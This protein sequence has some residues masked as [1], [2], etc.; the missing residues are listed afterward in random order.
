ML[1]LAL[2]LAP[3]LL[4]LPQGPMSG[5]V[6][7]NE[8]VVDDEGS[9]DREF[10]ELYNRSEQRVDLG[11]CVLEVLNRRGVR[12]SYAIPA[13]S[14]IEPCAHFVLG[15]PSVP[16]VD[17]SLG[18]GDLFVDVQAGALVLRDAQGVELDRLVYHATFGLWT[19]AGGAG[20]GF[21]GESTSFDGFETSISRWR[22]GWDDLPARAWVLQR[23]TPGEANAQEWRADG[24]DEFSGAVGSAHEGWQGTRSPLV[25]IDPLQVGPLDPQGRPWNPIALPRDSASAGGSGGNCGSVWN[26]AG[27]GSAALWR[28]EPVEELEVEGLFWLRSDA[29][30][31]AQMETWSFGIQGSTDAYAR[32]ADP[33]GAIGFVR[34]GNT[35]VAWI[36]QALD[37]GVTLYLVDHGDGGWAPIARSAPALR[38]SIL[39]RAGVNDGWQRLRLRASQGQLEAEFGGVLGVPGS[40]QVV[41]ATLQQSAIGGV[42]LGYDRLLDNAH[43]QP[44]RV[45]DLRV[46]RLG[47]PPLAYYGSGIAT[48]SGAPALRAPFCAAPGEARFTL[49]LSGL[50]PQAFAHF[51]LGAR[52]LAPPLDLGALGATSGVTL[53][54]DLELVCIARADAQGRATLPLPIRC[55]Q[56]L[57]GQLAFAQG[58][59]LDPLGSAAIPLASSRA[60]R[61]EL[62]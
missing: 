37:S 12:T 38:A 25:R 51:A 44:I 40:G 50:A 20:E 39:I 53:H 49:E 15:S 19:T 13:G 21:W 2:I 26:P 56:E 4:G 16:N 59:A 31:L 17:L 48:P 55:A 58:F 9:D 6:L 8:A 32:I 11:G 24:L 57:R 60:L 45:D 27:G 5:A 52:A 28:S 30:P 18:S 33:S 61:I 22:D 41:R 1:D 42:Y 43:A 23:A 36:L 3:A 14:F 54:V 10:V 46:S 62:R 35:G 29:L 47:T 7:L 34:S